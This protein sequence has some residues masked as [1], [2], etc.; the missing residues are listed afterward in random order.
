MAPRIYSKKRSINEQI[1]PSVMDTVLKYHL[2]YANIQADLKHIYHSINK[3]KTVEMPDISDNLTMEAFNLEIN[4][5]LELYASLDNT[6]ARINSLLKDKNLHSNRTRKIA[7]MLEILDKIMANTAVFFDLGKSDRKASVFIL[8]NLVQHATASQET[9]VFIDKHNSAIL[10]WG[11]SM[12][13]AGF[14]KTGSRKKLNSIDRACR[15]VMEIL[16]NDKPEILPT[17]H[18]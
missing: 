13:G 2:L 14:F 10:Q 3:I 15:Q 18:V 8:N 1:N 6:F 7:K 11:N 4:A 17:C 9:S 16:T 12:C 5:Y